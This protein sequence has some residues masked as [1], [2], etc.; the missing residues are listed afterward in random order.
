MKIRTDFV[1]NSSSSSFVIWGKHFEEDELLQNLSENGVKVDD[2]FD[3]DD[4][5]YKNFK[6]C[7]YVYG[8]GSNDVV[9]GLS[10]TAMHD[11]ETLS[12]FKLRIAEKLSSVKL[13]VGGLNEITFNKGVDYDGNLDFD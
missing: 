6:M 13:P 3:L 11:D 2:D 5:L 4:W 7:D 1:S 9:I 10:P 8:Y 12:Q